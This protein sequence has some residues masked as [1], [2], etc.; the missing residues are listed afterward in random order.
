MAY[1]A[2]RDIPAREE[3]TLNYHPKIMEET[4]L[5]PS[6]RKK[7]NEEASELERRKCYCGSS[8]CMGYIF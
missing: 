5:R 1:V 6:K 8:N 7:L 4:D 3:L 2:L